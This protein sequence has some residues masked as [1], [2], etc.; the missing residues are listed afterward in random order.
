[1]C[2][3]GNAIHPGSTVTIVTSESVLPRS[4]CGPQRS[5][6]KRCSPALD[7]NERVSV[8]RNRLAA[9]SRVFEDMLSIPSDGSNE[10]PISETRG[11]LD[12]FLPYCGQAKV[13]PFELDSDE[14]WKLIKAFDKYEVS[15]PQQVPTSSKS[16]ADL[17]G[18]ADRA[19]DG[20]RR[21][22]HR[23]SIATPT[24][25]RCGSVAEIP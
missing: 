19:R 20:R 3:L 4:S 12:L 18:M 24:L 1:M 9:Q 15:P 2:N 21:G 14:A 17:I 6:L 7:S 10:V 23:V 8:N 22:S 5:R 16:G 25:T 11:S 13:P